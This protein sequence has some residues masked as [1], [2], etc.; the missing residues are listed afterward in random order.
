M[1]QWADQKEYESRVEVL[2]QLMNMSTGPAIF[3]SGHVAISSA[4][5]L[6]HGEMGFCAISCIERHGKTAII[7]LFVYTPLFNTLVRIHFR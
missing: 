4:R 1:V 2:Q 5:N 6:P 3:N 7:Y